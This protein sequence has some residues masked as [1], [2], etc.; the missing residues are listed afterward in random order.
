M[1]ERAWKA[2]KDGAW[3]FDD[4]G[5]PFDEHVRKHLPGYEMIQSLA[6]STAMWNLT[7]GANVLDVGCSTGATLELLHKR[8]P[9]DFFSLGIDVEEGMIAKAHKRSPRSMF[10]CDD[11]RTVPFKDGQRFDVVLALFAFQFI[12]Q[13]DRLA[14]LDRVVAQLAPGG[15]MIL[16]EKCDARTAKAADLWQGIY[17]DW[18]LSNGIDPDEV[19]AKWASLRGQLVPWPA[20]AYESW[21][22]TRDL[23]GDVLWAWG[24]FRAWA[25]WTLPL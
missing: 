19:L 15:L 9:W 4:I 20:S 25:W 22:S 6:V 1:S 10:I 2:G 7:R 17:S 5:E 16:A 21:A 24:P 3:S 23:I 14:A 12:P 11:I 18:K 8:S 13:R